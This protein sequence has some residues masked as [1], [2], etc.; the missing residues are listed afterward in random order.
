MANAAGEYIKNMAQCVV[1]QTLDLSAYLED[2][3]ITRDQS[4][5]YQLAGAVLHA[6]LTIDGGHYAVHVRNKTG[7]YF[8]LD[9]VASPRVTQSSIHRLNNDIGIDVVLVAYVKVHKNDSGAA[10]SHAANDRG[11]PSRL[12]CGDDR[13]RQTPPY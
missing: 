3:D 9:D 8:R 5:T 11:L 13:R 1:T 7:D 4:A 6:G 10:C 12:D 2:E